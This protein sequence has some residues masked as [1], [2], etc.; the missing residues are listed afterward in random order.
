M[1]WHFSQN[2]SGGRFDFDQVKGITHHVIIEADSVDEANR[3]ATKIGIYFD[4]C[5]SDL[6]CPC[7][8]D[9]WYRVYG[10]G[11]NKPLLYGKELKQTLKNYMKFMESGFEVCVHF[12]SGEKVWY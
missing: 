7:C 10:K 6:D 1:F 2:N 12:K 8:G 11:D 5:E 3:L 9:R 4:G